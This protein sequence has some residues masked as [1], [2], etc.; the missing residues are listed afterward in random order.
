MKFK[1]FTKPGFLKEIGR[2]LLGQFFERFKVGL[3]DKKIEKRT[4]RFA[5]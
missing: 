5:D 2:G 3:A 4:Y 1:R